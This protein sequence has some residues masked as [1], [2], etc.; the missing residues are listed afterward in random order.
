MLGAVLLALLGGV[1]NNTL[2]P[3][4][5]PWTGRPALIPNQPDRD[6]PSHL[7][8]AWSG[9][10]FARDELGDH[11]TVVAIGAVMIVLGSL[12]L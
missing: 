7:K 6:P 10:R 12:V 2:N 9:L 11:A 8:G 5:V 4:G 1:V 3:H